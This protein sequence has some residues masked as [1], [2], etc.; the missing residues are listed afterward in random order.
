MRSYFPP[1]TVPE[2]V[3]TEALIAGGYQLVDVTWFNVLARKSM[4]PVPVALLT[5][6]T[7]QTAPLVSSCTYWEE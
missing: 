5:A 3:V 4:G 1:D 6:A 2:D 7:W